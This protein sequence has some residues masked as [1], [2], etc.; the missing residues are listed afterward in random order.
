MK[1]VVVDDMIEYRQWLKAKIE[2]YMENKDVQYEFFA[3]ESGEAFVEA[4]EHT[5][6]DIV[7][8]DIYMD[9]MDGMDAALKLREKDMDCKLVFLTTSTEH[10]SRGYAFMPRH[11]L[12]KPVEDFEFEQAMIN[13]QIK[14][15]LDVPFLSVMSDGVPLRIDTT[16]LMYVDFS[17]RNTRLH[18]RDNTITVSGS[19]NVIAQQLL[20]DKRFLACIKGVVVNMD[21][22]TSAQGSVFHLKNGEQLQMALRGKA[23]LL[24]QYHAY[25]LNRTVERSNGL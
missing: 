10:H 15:L 19:M 7:F 16:M 24:Q 3:F 11:Y 5:Y 14:R 21:Y 8:M 1:I 23:A 4:L 25:R 2:N 6:F 13:C 20:E 22:I 17:A 12:T 18:L 9:G